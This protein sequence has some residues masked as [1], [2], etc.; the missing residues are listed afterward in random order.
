MKTKQP[1]PAIY[2]EGNCEHN[3]CRQSNGFCCVLCVWY[4]WISHLVK[5][6]Q[7][8]MKPKEDTGYE[9]VYQDHE[10]R[11]VVDRRNPRPAQDTFFFFHSEPDHSVWSSFQATLE[12]GEFWL[13]GFGTQRARSSAVV[14]QYISIYNNVWNILRR[15]FCVSEQFCSS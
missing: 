5:K 1:W 14:N 4:N 10:Y 15:S 8:W 12:K 13:E 2:V 6:T 7:L 3:T 11:Q 9:T